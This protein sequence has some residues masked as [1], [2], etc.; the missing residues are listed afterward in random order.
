MRTEF[1]QSALNNPAFAHLQTKLQQRS[2]ASYLGEVIF[3]LGCFLRDAEDERLA[4]E[5]VTEAVAQYLFI[6]H[7]ST[8][9]GI[10]TLKAKQRDRLERRHAA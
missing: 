4:A 7:G 8:P 5:A 2:A 1:E 9:R 6:P 3:H 10:L